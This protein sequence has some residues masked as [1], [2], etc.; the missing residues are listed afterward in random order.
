MESTFEIYKGLTGVMASK[1][2]K[3]R[4]AANTGGIVTGFN[5]EDLVSSVMHDGDEVSFE[6]MS[7][8]FWLKV[9]F[10]MFEG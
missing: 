8:D 7:Q 5:D 1:M 10:R 9:L 2:I 4:G 3:V 6:L